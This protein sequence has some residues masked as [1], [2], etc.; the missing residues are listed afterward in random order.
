MTF[1]ALAVAGGGHRAAGWT[2]LVL[3][4]NGYKA[5]EA[6]AGDDGSDG[7]GEVGGSQQGE[8]SS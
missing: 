1:K 4:P 2:N 6:L 5:V 3:Q 8:Q 7:G